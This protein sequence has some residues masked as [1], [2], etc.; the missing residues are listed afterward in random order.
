MEDGDLNNQEPI[1]VEEY[2]NEDIFGISNDVT[3]TNPKNL[4][5]PSIDFATTKVLN[6]EDPLSKSSCTST[7]GRHLRNCLSLNVSKNK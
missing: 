1:E 4:G 5:D 2:E 3:T 6:E 7:L